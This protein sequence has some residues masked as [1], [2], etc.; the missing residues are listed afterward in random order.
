MQ[1]RTVWEIKN[2]SILLIPW[3]PTTPQ[4]ALAAGYELPWTGRDLAQIWHLKS[5]RSSKGNC[6]CENYQGAAQPCMST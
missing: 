4:A 6:S 1:L 3:E 5:S 2:E